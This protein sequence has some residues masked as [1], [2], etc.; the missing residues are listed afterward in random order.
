MQLKCNNQ[1]RD[2]IDWHALTAKEQAEFD[3]LASDDTQESASF[4]R[5]KGLVYDLGE[6][7]RITPSIAP[8]PQREGWEHFDGY[9]SDSAFSG[10][11]VRYVDDF[12]R[13]IVATYFC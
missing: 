11:L 12:E 9:A 1:P 6:F 2:V 4:F 10:T 13:V 8:H 5:Y 3:Y 7:A